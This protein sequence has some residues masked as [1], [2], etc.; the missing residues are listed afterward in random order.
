MFVTVCLFVCLFV[1]LSAGLHKK[2]PGQFS[3][4][5]VEGCSTGGRRNSLHS[6]GDLNHRA[7][8]QMTFEMERAF[9]LGRGL[10]PLRV[11]F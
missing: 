7:D 4:N 2:L 11:P 9:H 6:G 5:V 1:C 8:P 3:L 10:R